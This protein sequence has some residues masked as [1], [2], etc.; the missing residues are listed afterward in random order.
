MFLEN[1]I[2]IMFQLSISH[3]LALEKGAFLH[4][5]YS[6]ATQLNIE[7][8]INTLLLQ[9][10]PQA[11]KYFVNLSTLANEYTEEAKSQFV[12]LKNEF[13]SLFLYDLKLVFPGVISA[14][15]NRQTYQ[16]IDIVTVLM[17]LR[18]KDEKIMELLLLFKQQM[19]PISNASKEAEFFNWFEKE[20]IIQ[21][22]NLNIK[23]NQWVN[24]K[25]SA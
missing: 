6:M 7:Q 8:D 18:K 13:I 2:F 22:N 9:I 15:E 4:T 11:H 20:F 25:I 16:K 1:M 19:L 5:I 14:I 24:E 17:F 23:L 3:F 10:Y 21:R 12:E